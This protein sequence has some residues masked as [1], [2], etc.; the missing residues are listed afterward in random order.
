VRRCEVTIYVK[1][2]QSVQPARAYFNALKHVLTFFSTSEKKR[3]AANLI[4]EVLYTMGINKWAG[5]AQ[6]G[7][8]PKQG[9]RRSI[10]DFRVY[11]KIRHTIIDFSQNSL[12][13]RNNHYT[14][15][16]QASFGFMAFIQNIFQCH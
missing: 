7:D 13:V 4:E 2:L 6:Y 8:R 12:I 14:I 11:M 9:N 1:S 10:P 15:K 3:K 5:I 16:I